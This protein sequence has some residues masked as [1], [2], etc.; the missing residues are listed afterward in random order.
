MALFARV[1]D[2]NPL[3]DGND[4]VEAAKAELGR[5]TPATKLER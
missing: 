2:G 3:S 1:I 4:R 5:A